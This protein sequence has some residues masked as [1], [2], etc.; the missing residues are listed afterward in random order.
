MASPTFVAEG[1]GTTATTVGPAP[2]TAT[3]SAPASSAAAAASAVAGIQGGPRGLGDRVEHV[4]ADQ[5]GFAALES[6][7]QPRQ[8]G[9]LRHRGGAGNLARQHRAR[10]GRLHLVARA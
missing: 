5:V 3:P 8:P 7:Q 1:I 4:A 6:Q 10:L 2:L 9:R